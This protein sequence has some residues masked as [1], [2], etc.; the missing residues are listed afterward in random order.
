M[1]ALQCIYIALHFYVL[2]FE[3]L[4]VSEKNGECR[5]GGLCSF[6]IYTLCI[7]IYMYILLSDDIYI[8]I[9]AFTSPRKP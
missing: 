9:C 6:M 1:L 8:Y 2:D 7:Y 4:Q 5:G 3:F